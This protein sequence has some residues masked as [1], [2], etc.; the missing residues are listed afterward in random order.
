[1]KTGLELRLVTGRK[2]SFYRVFANLLRTSWKLLLFIA[3]WAN[4]PGFGQCTT[5][6]PYF[7]DFEGGPAWTSVS[8]NASDWAWGAPNHTFVIHNAGSGLNCWNVGGLTG[9]F[10]NYS[11]QSYLLSPCFDFSNLQYP[12][13]TFKL[14]YDCEYHWDGGNLQ[15]SIDGGISWQTIGGYNETSDCNTENWY[16]FNAVHYL[17]SPSWIHNNPGWSGNVEVGGVGWDSSHFSTNCLGGHGQ[18]HWLEAAHCLQGLGGQS[19]VLLR[20]SFGAG[21]ACNNFDGFSIDSI[22]I[23]NGVPNNTLFTASCSSAQGEAFFPLSNCLVANTFNWNFGDPASG[24]SNLSSSTQPTHIFSASGDYLVSLTTSG[25]EC[26]PPGTNT[27]LVQVPGVTAAVLHSVLCYGGN[28]G[29]ATAQI[30]NGTFPYTISWQPSNESG[31]TASQLSAGTCTVNVQ[32]GAGCVFSNTLTLTQPNPLLIDSA[33]LH[34]ATCGMS[35]GSATIYPAGGSPGYSFAWLPS[36]GN[37]SIATGIAGGNYTVLVSDAHHCSISEGIDISDVGGP[38]LTTIVQNPV[39]CFGGA[40]GSI[41]SS[42]FSGTPPYSYTWAPLGGNA[43]T[44]TNLPA[45]SYTLFVS[46]QNGCQSQSVISLPAPTLS[47][48]GLANSENTQCV[49]LGS[50]TATASGGTPPYTFLWIPFGGNANFAL[51]LSVG[52][53]TLQVTDSNHCIS[54]AMFIILPPPALTLNVHAAPEKICK[55]DS[56]FLIATGAHQFTWT[57]GNILTDSL[58]QSFWVQPHSTITYSV[59]GQFGTCHADTTISITVYEL[60]EIGIIPTPSLICRGDS[61]KLSG[62]GGVSYSWSGAV[63]NGVYFIPSQ[64]ETFVVT[65]TDSNA[66]KNSFSFFLKVDSIP[67]LIAVSDSACAGDSCV[68]S[69]TGATQFLWSNGV[70][71]NA[72]AANPEAT[73]I[74]TVIGTNLDGCRSVVSATATIIAPPELS[75][76]NDTN[77]CPG[78]T[79]T[80]N[81]YGATTYTWMPGSFFGHTLYDSPIA[82]T[83]YTASGSNFFGCKSS[84]QVIVTL[85]PPPPLPPVVFGPHVL[86]QGQSAL[87]WISNNNYTYIWTT[88]NLSLFESDTMEIN[89]QGTYTVT[90]YDPCG[91][92][93]SIFQ[94]ILSNPEA[95]FSADTLQG[96]APLYI[97]FLNTSTGLAL[98]SIWNFS[99]NENS[100][101][102]NP[103]HNF[104]N[105]GEYPIQ[106]IVRDTMGC[107][108][109]AT[110]IIKV[111]DDAP[112]LIIPNI[113][114]PN[115]D[116]VNDF[117]T[118]KMEGIQYFRCRIFDRWGVLVY[119]WVG[120]DGRWDG[121]ESGRGAACSDGTYFF[122]ADYQIEKQQTQTRTGYITLLR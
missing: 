55:G 86:C 60:P 99:D 31:D 95:A 20:F 41:S 114:T 104:L 73:S 87:N 43:A 38:V 32:D 113:F 79:V 30:S 4:K 71:G 76:S 10:Y 58:E 89:Q 33:T 107:T 120:L 72:I 45:G 25:G 63:Q 91:S 54:D 6:F 119:E 121:T 21:Y 9:A 100:Y 42:V 116:G 102:F 37:S 77:I 36:G 96:S 78:S 90:A 105:P 46:D 27:V 93:S 118:V 15:S 44:T 11:E 88:P 68:L 65:G 122:I 51:P 34:Q 53:Y 22:F 57:P 83:T 19:Q 26:N 18:G 67:V 97:R 70:S 61:I 52:N 106:L 3:L 62:S 17:N 39:R 23:S 82:T 103:S 74:Y 16:N 14:F 85:L 101:I 109:T 35:N 117:L 64:S 7:E 92:A 5:I 66:C 111:L 49:S 1:M 81:A 13:I 108:D 112:I 12:H 115:G 8:L 24:S 50:A 59:S 47:L 48:T 75:V 69:V 2:K 80:I 110:V 40:D 29:N 98:T 94:V 56:T 84:M 28:D